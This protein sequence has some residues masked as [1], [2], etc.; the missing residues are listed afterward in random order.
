MFIDKIKNNLEKKGLSQ[1]SINLYIR[2]LKKLN[3]DDEIKNLDFLKDVDKIED[4]IKDLKNNTKRGYYISLVSTLNSSGL[5]YKKLAN[6]YYKLLID[7]DK[8]IKETPINEKSLTQKNN[9]IDWNEVKTIYDNLKKNV[10]IYKRKKLNEKEYNNLLHFVILSLYVLLPPRR[11]QD[12]LKMKIKLDDDNKYNYL[13]MKNKQFIFNVYKTSK[14]YG[15]QKIDI[16]EELYNILNDYLKN[17]IDNNSDLLLINYNG[18]PFKNINSITRILNKIFNKN[19]SSSMLRHIYLSSK[20]N[21]INEEKKDDA[22]KMA[23]SLQTQAD[24]IKV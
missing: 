16:P 6:K 10:K 24:Y 20:Y 22:Q 8:K 13:D 4:K 1:S 7:I 2:N 9:W 14:H 15:E 11:N 21:D 19:I 18:E 17:R 23:H 5:K 3:N 12:W